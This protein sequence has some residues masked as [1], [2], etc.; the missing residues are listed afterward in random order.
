VTKT[1]I[2]KKQKKQKPEKN[3]KRKIIIGKSKIALDF[4]LFYNNI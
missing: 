3:R 1:K 4:H 2:G